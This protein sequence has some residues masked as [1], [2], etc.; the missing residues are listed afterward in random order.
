MRSSVPRVLGVLA[1]SG[2][3]LATAGCGGS[4]NNKSACNEMKAE[5]Q[6][7]GPKASQQINNPSGMAQLY[8]DGASK[9]RTAA[10]KADGDVKKSGNDVATA[11]DGLASVMRNAAAG[12]VKQPDAT[13][14]TT[15]GADLKKA[16]GY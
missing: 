7:L 14:L 5:L 12:Q 6:N 16:C 4:G 13:A 11:L 10:N 9:I 15:A 2:A 8:T 1:V 3:L